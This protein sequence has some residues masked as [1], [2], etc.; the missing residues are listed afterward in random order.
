MPRSSRTAAALLAVLGLGLASWPAISTAS[1]PPPPPSV[2]D[3][4]LDR[5][6]HGV[7]ALEVLGGKLD[8]A[9]RRN[10]MR[11]DELAR[12]L[13]TDRT[14]WLDTSGS[15]FYVEPAP[16]ASTATETESAPYP[17]DQTFSLHSDP[18]AQRT[19][20]LDFDGQTI[21][22]TAWNAQFGVSTDAQPSFDADGRVGFS[23]GELD[24]VQSVYER[25][26]EDFAPFNVDVTTEDP[27]E[28]ALDRSSSIDQEFGI[29]V[30]VTPSA[31]A[32]EVICESQC[33]GVAYVG[34]FDSTTS[35]YNP[36]WVF[37]N[38]LGNA[39]KS[40]GEAVSHEAGHTL[41][42]NHDGTSQAAYYAGQGIWAPVM[43]VGY[44]QPLTQW[45]QGEYANATN[46]EDDLAVMRS[47][48]APGR[49]DDHG[50]TSATATPV[51]RG[52]STQTGVVTTRGDKDL[53]A[54]ADSCSGTVGATADPAGTS[55]NLDIRLRLLGADGVVLAAANPASGANSNDVAT[56][57]SASFQAT[58]PSGSYYVQADGVGALDPSTTGYS[59]YGSLGRY[60]LTVNG[61]AQPPAAPSIGEA[62]AG[63]EGGAITATARWTAPSSNG[64]S[65]ITGYRVNA[66]RLSSGTVVERT[67]SSLLSKSTPALEMTL[68]STGTY[69]FTVVARNAFG[70]SDASARSAAVAGR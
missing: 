21:T 63:L 7:R 64:G 59:D 69:R 51:S 53:F 50:G 35:G 32:Q 61:C 46:Q 3:S 43:G 2:D 60:T 66:L 56:G 27:G 55:P 24:V 23:A 33:G 28:A 65:A 42:L 6:S 22:G 5:P 40:I 62:A 68:P 16:T 47:Y 67:R 52:D 20:L 19:I 58:V 48:G 14:A 13:R 54:L 70:V 12:L 9:A 11:A 44:N 29:R 37:S 15:L 49:T 1:P 41:G 34:V 10:D 57:L 38:A 26:S 17:Y 8:E 36:A 30:L 25:V 39:V 31:Q 4:L 45:S 18:G